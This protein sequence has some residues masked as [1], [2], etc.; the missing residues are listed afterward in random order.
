MLPDLL[1]ADEWSN[2]Q[3]EFVMLADGVFSPVHTMGIEV[4][5]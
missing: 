2:E 4:L 1:F 3:R 5:R